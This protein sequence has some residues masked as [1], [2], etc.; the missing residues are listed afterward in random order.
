MSNK[1]TCY[2]VQDAMDGKLIASFL[3]HPMLYFPSENAT[4]F[5]LQRILICAV[6]KNKIMLVASGI[7]FILDVY[8]FS[9]NSH[10]K[11]N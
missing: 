6:I 1:P 7:V 5:L 10:I 3:H 2:N 9:V 8:I 11:I 4:I